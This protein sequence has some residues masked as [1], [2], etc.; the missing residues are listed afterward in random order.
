MSVLALGIGAFVRATA[1]FFSVHLP[2]YTHPQYSRLVPICPGQLGNRGQLSSVDS[3]RNSHIIGGCCAVGGRQ[4][5]GKP[6]S[7]SHSPGHMQTSK[8]GRAGTPP[9]PAWKPLD[10]TRRR[11]PPRFKMYGHE[12]ARRR[13]QLLFVIFPC[14]LQAPK[15]LKGKLLPK[16]FFSLFLCNVIRKCCTIH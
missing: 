1:H 11:P 16:L 7:Q 13:C 6:M 15:I 5:R 2:P 10:W 4:Q 3:P 14:K 8:T 9:S 12:T